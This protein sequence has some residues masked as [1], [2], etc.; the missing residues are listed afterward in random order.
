MCHGTL[1]KYCE[2]KL[3]AQQASRRAGNATQPSGGTRRILW[4]ILMLIPTASCNNF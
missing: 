2:N 4:E 3:A 1:V